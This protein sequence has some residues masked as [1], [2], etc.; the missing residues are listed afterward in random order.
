MTAGA[1]A[2]VFSFSLQ[3]A[4]AELRQVKQSI[5]GMD[6]APCAYGIQKDLGNLKGATNIEVSLNNANAVIG[7]APNNQVSLKDIRKV[8]RN[9]GFQPHG[10]QIRATGKLQKKDG[11]FVLATNDD[12]M[13]QLKASEESRKTLQR[14]SDQQVKVLVTARVSA[15]SERLIVQKAVQMR[16]VTGELSRQDDG[17][18]L[19]TE[20]G[21]QYALQPAEE[22]KSQWQALKKADTSTRLV[23]QGTAAS[24]S[25]QQPA[26][27]KVWR[28]APADR[29][30]SAAGN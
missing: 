23:I 29:Q 20:S 11:S 7:L 13:H 10:A 4:Q 28:V 9:G 16:E 5:R 21:K 14:F 19:R 17:F 8:V 18:V 2:A 12:T 27:L 24:G 22:A 3:A 26:A 1:V 15:E 25:D 30:A 6:C